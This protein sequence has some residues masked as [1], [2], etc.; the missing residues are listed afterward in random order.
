M[1]AWTNFAEPGMGPFPLLDMHKKR[2]KGWSEKPTQSLIYLP[3]DEEKQRYSK[4]WKSLRNLLSGRGF[5]PPP[6][7]EAAL[8]AE[9][10]A[11]W[12]AT[13]TGFVLIKLVWSY[14]LASHSLPGKW[15]RWYR[16]SLW[17]L[18]VTKAQY[19]PMSL[20]EMVVTRPRISGICSGSTRGICAVGIQHAGWRAHRGLPVG[21]QHHLHVR[22]WRESQHR[23]RNSQFGYDYLRGDG[24]QSHHPG[25]VSGRFTAVSRG[26]RSRYE[27]CAKTPGRKGRA[28]SAVVEEIVAVLRAD[29]EG[30][31]LLRRLH[32]MEAQKDEQQ[33]QLAAD[34]LKWCSFVI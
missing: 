3:N 28:A 6:C 15:K 2:I 16:H 26:H 19:H 29:Q 33:R 7:H 12:R 14:L 18:G 17:N 32:E 23:E 31:D 9:S 22:Q 24:F 1:V 20:P 34:S 30:A 10:R 25:R 27:L 11:Y 5:E 13:F 4:Y 21:P 8:V